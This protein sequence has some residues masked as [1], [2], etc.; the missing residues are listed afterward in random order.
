MPEQVLA[1]FVE[2][3]RQLRRI[4]PREPRHVALLETAK[5][6]IVK[7]ERSR[8]VVAAYANPSIIL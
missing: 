7:D 3:K 5:N 6:R 1:M 2:G 4:V 8:V